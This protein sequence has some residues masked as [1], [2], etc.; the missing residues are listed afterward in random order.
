MW[1]LCLGLALPGA[2]LC[3]PG[4]TEGGTAIRAVPPALRLSRFDGVD[5]VARRREMVDRLALAREAEPAATGGEVAPE[6]TGGEAESDALL[7]LAELHLAW[8][9]VPEGLS[10]LDALSADLPRPKALRR[11]A[12]RLALELLDSRDRTLSPRSSALL[13]EDMPGWRDQPMMRILAGYDPADPAASRPELEAAAARID[14]YSRAIREIAVPRLLDVAVESGAWQVARDLA[15]RLSPQDRPEA[16]AAYHYLLGR[17]AES[18]GE[19]IAAFDHYREASAGRDLWAHRARLALAEL[20]LRTDT[21]PPEEARILL[22]QA[23]RVWSGDVHA[24]RLLQRLARLDL[25]MGDDVAALEVLAGIMTRA[26]D[27]EAAALARQQARSLWEDFYRRGAEGEL[28]LGDFLSGHRRIAP[29]YRFHAGFDLAAETFADRF[30]AEGATQV[31]A[32]EYGQIHDYLLVARDLGLAEVAEARLDGL[33]LKRAQ[34]LLQGGQFEDAARVLA[35]GLGSG[36][37]ALHDR[38]TML[39]AQLHSAAGEPA[40]VIAAQPERPG[41]DYLRLRAGAYFDR[42]DW[43]LAQAE[44]ARLLDRMGDQMPAS[45]AIRMLLSAHRAGDLRATQSLARR[46][47]ELK[48]SLQWAEIARSLSDEAPGIDP[49]RGAAVQDSVAAVDRTLQSLDALAGRGA[50]Q[51]S[52][53]D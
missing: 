51:D 23:R 27:S 47:P 1:M 3:F 40:E 24:V 15:A 38:M 17:T 30:L 33:R 37:P 46:F 39:R 48:G 20:G 41:T 25:E 31:A 32:D 12:L 13:S 50:S 14:D 5:F 7:D 18:G 2:G 19:L 28:S 35:E 45:D 44:Y 9:M 21:L 34:A 53:Q 10:Y 29:D 11:D 16:R 36:A 49:L 6:P 22:E 52:P 4:A 26:P 42:G 8:A 43:S